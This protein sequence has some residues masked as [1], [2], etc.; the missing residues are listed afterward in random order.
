MLILKINLDRDHR[1]ASTD[2]LIEALKKYI[3]N[4]LKIQ[5]TKIMSDD[6]SIE[7]TTKPENIIEKDNETSIEILIS[8]KI[9]INNDIFNKEENYNNIIS[10]L[11]KVL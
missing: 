8:K 10:E 9:I 4:D 11:K 2:K 6:N 7:L 3:N 1:N 5:D